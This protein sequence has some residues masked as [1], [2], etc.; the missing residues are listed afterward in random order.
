MLYR[1]QLA[2]SQIL[3]HNFSGD[4][5]LIA[6]VGC[7]SNYHAVTTTAGPTLQYSWKFI[8]DIKTEI[9]EYV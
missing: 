7:K 8:L 1:V 4:R 9:V 2:I 6:Q 5:I 3:T